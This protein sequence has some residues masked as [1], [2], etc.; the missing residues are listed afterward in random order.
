M[1]FV[2]QLQGKN[3]E[4]CINFIANNNF[5]EQYEKFRSRSTQSTKRTRWIVD[6]EIPIFAEDRSY[7]ARYI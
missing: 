2:G 7:I 5:A 3:I 4:D 1:S 6:R